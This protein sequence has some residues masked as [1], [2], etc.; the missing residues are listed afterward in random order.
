MPKNNK[1]SMK[2]ENRGNPTSNKAEKLTS[3]NNGV[4]DDSCMD[5]DGSSPHGE[6]KNVSM[7][8]LVRVDI[9]KI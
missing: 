2:E 3:N 6:S 4:V 5:I 7:P 1:R 8:N 9:V